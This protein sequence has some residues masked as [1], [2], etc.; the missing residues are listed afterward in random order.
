MKIE[1]TEVTGTEYMQAL[2]L[3][4]KIGGG[5]ASALAVAWIKADL[6]NRHALEQA[7][8]DLIGYYVLLVRKGHRA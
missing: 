2:R 3:M 6:S 1:G 5:F 4:E 8:F 7:F